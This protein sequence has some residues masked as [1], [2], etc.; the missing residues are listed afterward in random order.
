M[1]FLGNVKGWPEKPLIEVA[2]LKR[3][4]DLPVSKRTPGSVPIY[5]ANGENGSHDEI[6]IEGPGVVTGR[7]GTIGKVHFVDGSYWPL[8]TSLYVTDF[9][10]NDPKW[11]YYMLRAFHLE[12]FVEGAGVPTLNRN[13][14]HGE[15]IPV[16]P[17][18]EQKRIAAILDKADAIRHKRQQAIEL[19][20][21][22]LRSVFLDLF[23]DPVTNPNG[24]DVK[25]ISGVCEEIVDCVNRTAPTVERETPFKMIR[26]T[27][28]RHYTLNLSNLKSVEE[29]VFEKWVRRLRPQRGDVILTRE[30]PAGEAALIDT[31][32][33]IF[34]GQRLMHYRPNTESM[35][36]DFMLYEL[37][38]AGVQRQIVK[39]HAGST[40]VHLSVP[41]CKKFLVRVPP[42]EK[43]R[44]FL[45]IRRTA[46]RALSRQVQKGEAGEQLFGSLSKKAFAGE[47]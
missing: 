15:I 4:Y 3:G 43:Q 29:D 32:M 33:D 5:A 8:N 10:G 11:V 14:V 41:E 35:T 40:V 1:S 20:D 45:S 36:A 6:K 2:P 23:G 34:L 22:F 44:E 24:W 30:A 17:P 37:M 46:L 25:E 39:M 9:K 27:N 26:T 42:I 18:E 38:S 13:L 19:A 31:D 47:L 12:R 28:V 21:Q 7:S 16:P